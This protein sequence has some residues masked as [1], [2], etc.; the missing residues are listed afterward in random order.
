LKENIKKAKST[1]PHEIFW[2]IC[3]D[4]GIVEYK[5]KPDFFEEWIYPYSA[6]THF[7]HTRARSQI[8]FV[9]T[10]FKLG[11]FSGYIYVLDDDNLLADGIFDRDYNK[12][13]SLIYIYQQALNSGESRGTVPKKGYIDQAQILIHS[14]IQDFYPLRKAGGD[15]EFIERICKE[16]PYKVLGNI[17]VHYNKIGNPYEN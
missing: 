1:S 7:F 9:L 14:D 5:E 8:N 12:E 2:H 11:L 3:F 13:E 6:R 10:H 16:H 17:C 15:G 4:C